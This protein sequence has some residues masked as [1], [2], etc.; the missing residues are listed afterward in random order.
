MSATP[1]K[2][3]VIGSTGH[4]HVTCVEWG[5]AQNVNIVD[6]DQVVVNCRPLTSE[7]LTSL[8]FDFFDP[9]RSGLVRLLESDGQ[10]IA[11]G[12][13]AQ[14]GANVSR[15]NRPLHSY[16]WSPIVVETVKENGDTIS[17]VRNNY[18]LYLEKLRRW[19]YWYR[20]AASGYHS[21]EMNEYC[22]RVVGRHFEVFQ[23]PIVTNR[24]GSALAVEYMLVIYG[25]TGES[26]RKF[27]VITLLPDIPDLDSRE[28][29][30]LVLEDLL[31]L[32]QTALPPAWAEALVVP[33]VAQLEAEMATRNGQI[34][35]LEGEITDL[36]DRKNELEWYRKLLYES[37]TELENVFSK[38]L[39]R[40]GGSVTPAKYSREEFVLDFEGQLS[41][42]EC[43]GVSSRSAS[44][45]NVRQLADYMLKYEE[46]V[47]VTG[48]G[49][50][51]VN[52]WR[53]LPASE[54]DQP[55]TPIFPPNVIERAVEL[56]IALVS[57]VEFFR[58]F[59]DF[60]AGQ[61]EGTTILRRLSSSSGVVT[62][63]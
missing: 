62:F 20:L 12:V 39:Q 10:I 51:F 9:V 58:A 36:E 8:K 5:D 19:S 37:G 63:T 43:K 34:K 21:P 2:T 41:L 52:A 25:A 23:Q 49:I 40:M 48:K 32:P 3:L 13:G 38:C 33:G 15:L 45:T 22:R 46:D 18:P 54:R 56:K 31:G 1:K 11:I 60:L 4:S 14:Q 61:V 24:Y 16:S 6:F 53:N 50:L 59:C 29:T 44:L 27:G 26:I 57:S 30:N 47:G 7:Y 17:R 28:A 35:Q 55:G 42:V